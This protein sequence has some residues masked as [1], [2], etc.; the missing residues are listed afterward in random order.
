MLVRFGNKYMFKVIT[1]FLFSTLLVGCQTQNAAP[2]NALDLL[3]TIAFVPSTKPEASESA[4]S[5]ITKDT[6][7]NATV[8]T[9]KG[10]FVIALDSTSAPKTVDNFVS[11]AKSD[12]YKDLTFHRVEDWVVQGGDPD[13]NGTGGGSMPTELSQTPFKRGSVGVA[14]GMDIN[15]SNDAQF[16]VCTKDCDWLTGAYTLFGQVTEGMEVVDAMEIGD[17]IKSISL[18]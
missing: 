17:T 5:S 2:Q 14:R 12:F 11:K 13:G 10:A 18:E 3:P 6:P 15:I 16:F 7:M 1:L 4:T 9:S 8:T